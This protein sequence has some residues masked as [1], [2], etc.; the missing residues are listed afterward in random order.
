MT[1]AIDVVDIGYL[2]LGFLLGG[3]FTG[4]N[5]RRLLARLFIPP[6]PVQRPCSSRGSS[7]SKPRRS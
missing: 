7:G 6:S 1:H 5:R 4:V 2:M 3:R